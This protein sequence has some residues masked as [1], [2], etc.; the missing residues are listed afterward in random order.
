[1]NTIKMMLVVGVLL[2][3]A[4]TAFAGAK[5]QRATGRKQVTTLPE[6]AIAQAPYFTTPQQL[7]AKFNQVKIGWTRAQVEAL[8]GKYQWGDASTYNYFVR[9]S[10]GFHHTRVINFNKAGRVSKLGG[11]A[12]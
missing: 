12:G 3:Q 7:D 1:M 5:D 2:V 6:G 9:V 8:L 4:G 11:G 10:G